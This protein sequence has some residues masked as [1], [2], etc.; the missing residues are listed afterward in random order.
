MRVTPKGEVSAVVP[1]ARHGGGGLFEVV[2]SDAAGEGQREKGEGEQL[3]MSG[4]RGGFNSRC[5]C[6]LRQGPAFRG[7]KG[8]AAGEGQRDQ[9]ESDQLAHCVTPNEVSA[10]AVGARSGGRRLLDVDED[11]AGDG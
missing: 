2:D 6:T 10:V 3:R 9:G 4:L 5:Y 11:A 8:D 1:G 7:C